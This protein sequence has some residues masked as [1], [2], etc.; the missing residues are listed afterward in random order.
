VVKILALLGIV[1]AEVRIK[2]GKSTR[3]E[4]R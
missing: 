2:R 3:E 1:D 4:I